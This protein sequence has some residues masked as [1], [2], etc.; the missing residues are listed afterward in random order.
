MDNNLTILVLM[1]VSIA[2]ALMLVVLTSWT[3]GR[4]TAAGTIAAKA[5]QMAA[6]RIERLTG[7]NERLNGQIDQLQERIEV[8]ERIATDPAERTARE[9]EKLR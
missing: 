3:K 9:I 7:E 2:A 1:A 5:D 6:G 8:L 4:H